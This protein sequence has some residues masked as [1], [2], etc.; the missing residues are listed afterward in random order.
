MFTALLIVILLVL[1]FYAARTAGGT[2]DRTEHITYVAAAAAFAGSYMFFG[3][4]VLVP[5]PDPPKPRPTASGGAIPIAA[6]IRGTV[7]QV[8]NLTHVTLS[9][10]ATFASLGMGGDTIVDCAFLALGAAELTARLGMFLASDMEFIQNIVATGFEGGP[11]A[12]AARA[13]ALLRAMTPAS[14]AKLFDLIRSGM[15]TLLEVAG[16]VL[17]AIIPDDGG[18]IAVG[19]SWL[20]SIGGAIGTPQWFSGL[21]GVYNLV[22]EGL[23]AYVESEAKLEALF[24]GILDAVDSTVTSADV[25]LYASATRAIREASWKRIALAALLPSTMAPQIGL[26]VAA[27]FGPTREFVRGR[28]REARGHVEVAADLVQH[29]LGLLFA[30]AYV[31][32]SNEA[33]VAADTAIGAPDQQAAHEMSTP[34]QQIATISEA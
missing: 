33:S 31:L 19:A 6:I 1:V 22:P 5:R 16:T 15:Q 12:V 32:Q 4:D 18:A 27:Q 23:Q 29:A 10:G 11:D 3:P 13:A 34:D 28:I 26:T 30:A 14:R 17:S 21:R 20:G 9:T 8:A 25:G 2:R 24:G 7:K